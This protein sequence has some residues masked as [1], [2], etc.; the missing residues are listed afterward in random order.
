LCDEGLLAGD[1]RFGHTFA[2]SELVN[3]RRGWDDELLTTR[4]ALIDAP[5]GCVIAGENAL[6][7]GTL[8]ANHGD[9]PIAGTIAV[10][11]L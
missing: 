4:P 7:T 8:Q 1:W 10:L 3:L 6:A 2:E 5:G 9:E 11:G